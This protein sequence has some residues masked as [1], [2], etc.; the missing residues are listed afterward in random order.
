M[1]NARSR[2]S[3]PFDYARCPTLEPE[4]K[5]AILRSWTSSTD[6][7]PDQAVPQPQSGNGPLWPINDAPERSGARDGNPPFETGH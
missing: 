5:R 3:Y 4:V 1:S 2:L 6:R 7:V